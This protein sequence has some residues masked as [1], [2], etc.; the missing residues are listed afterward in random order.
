MSWRGLWRFLSGAGSAFDIGGTL[1][2][3]IYR[4]KRRPPSSD[5]QRLSTYSRNIENDFRRAFDTA[6]DSSG[7]EKN[8]GGNGGSN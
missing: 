6:V 7:I 4:T 2:P 1:R 3:E 5:A 8:S